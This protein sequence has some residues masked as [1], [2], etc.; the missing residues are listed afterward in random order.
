MKVARAMDTTVICCAQL[1]RDAASKERPTRE[2]MGDSYQLVRD[3]DVILILKENEGSSTVDLWIDKNR[4]GPGSVLIPTV[5]ERE[6][7][8]FRE[9]HNASR[10]PDY[11]IGE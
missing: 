7:Q 11:R 4:Q 5:F 10:V 9:A 1:R 8:T 2:D 6:S 3:A